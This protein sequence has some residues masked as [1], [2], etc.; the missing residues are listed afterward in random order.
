MQLKWFSPNLFCFWSIDCDSTIHCWKNRSE[1]ISELFVEV[2]S[3][4]YDCD[5]IWHDPKCQ[6]QVQF[7]FSVILKRDQWLRNH[8]MT[9]NALV[10]CQGWRKSHCDFGVPWCDSKVG[11]SSCNRIAQNKWSVIDQL[12]SCL[13]NLGYVILIIHFGLLLIRLIMVFDLGIRFST[14]TFVFYECFHYPLHNHKM[15]SISGYLKLL[16]IKSV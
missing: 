6:I 12:H 9:P 14:W 7:K 2:I 8:G 13:V 16:L 5:L 10:T 3:T 4:S 1:F 15:H 11:R